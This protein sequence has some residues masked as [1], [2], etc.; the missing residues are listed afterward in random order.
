MLAVCIGVVFRRLLTTRTPVQIRVKSILAEYA[1]GSRYNGCDRFTGTALARGFE[2]CAQAVVDTRITEFLTGYHGKFTLGRFMAS[3]T[4]IYR[5]E[6]L[7]Y[8]VGSFPPFALPFSEV[9]VK[10][11]G[12]PFHV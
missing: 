2:F 5:V 8:S 6:T 12:Q 1:V 4:G 7:I 10:L 11:H 9:S 3:R